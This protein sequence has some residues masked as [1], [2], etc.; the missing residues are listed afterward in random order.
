MAPIVPCPDPFRKNREGSGHETAALNV[1]QVFLKVVIVVSLNN[2]ILGLPKLTLQQF[3]WDTQ[4]HSVQYSISVLASVIMHGVSRCT[5]K[6]QLIAQILAL[7]ISAWL[8][9][10]ACFSIRLDYFQPLLLAACML[11]CMG[12]FSSTS[13]VVLAV[14]SK[15]SSIASYMLPV[16]IPA[17]GFSFAPVSLG[18]RYL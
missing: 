18:S 11:Y 12:G 10:N 15:W 7:I 2:N 17:I 3:K 1:W 4:L 6:L 8:H 9:V 5:S 16:L 14:S 13:S